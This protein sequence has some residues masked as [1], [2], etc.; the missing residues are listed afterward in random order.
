M[1]SQ[2]LQ[3]L[4]RTASV[5]ATAQR[6]VGFWGPVTEVPLLL[7]PLVALSSVLTLALLT[8]LAAGALTVLIVA[9]SAL[10]VLLTE[11]FGF[12]FELAA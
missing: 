2:V 11:V 3:L 4:E 9:V 6:W 5:V 8:G 1:L 12:S 10:Y 7:S